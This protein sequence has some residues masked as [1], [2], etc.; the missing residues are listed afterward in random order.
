MDSRFG[1][2]MWS[3]QGWWSH[4]GFQEHALWW[5]ISVKIEWEWCWVWCQWYVAS[6]VGGTLNGS[7]SGGNT[8]KCCNSSCLI[9]LMVKKPKP[10]TSNCCNMKVCWHLM[11]YERRKFQPRRPSISKATTQLLSDV[12]GVQGWFST[13]MDLPFFLECQFGFVFG[14]KMFQKSRVPSFSNWMWGIFI[15]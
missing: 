1:E 3:F 2:G 7:D 5:M 8:T 14:G 12:S 6:C 4:F 9:L 10:K 15:I 11:S 13:S